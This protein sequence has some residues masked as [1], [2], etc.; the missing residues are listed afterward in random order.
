[1]LLNKYNFFKMAQYEMWL[2]LDFSG[3][4]RSILHL[5]FLDSSIFTILGSSIPLTNLR[6]WDIDASIGIN[7]IWLQDWPF[8]QLDLSVIKN[9]KIKNSGASQ[10][11]ICEKVLS[12]EL[13]W[14]GR[15]WQELNDKDLFKDLRVC[16]PDTQLGNTQSVPQEERKTESSYSK[17]YIC[18]NQSCILSLWNG[19]RW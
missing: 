8:L 15:L 17:K 7:L 5:R 11:S 1:M 13:K 12:T 10:F 14:I 18:E 16:K 2:R 4:P 3:V 9:R 19:P 6:K